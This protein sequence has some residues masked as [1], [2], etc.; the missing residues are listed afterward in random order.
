LFHRAEFNAWV[1]KDSEKPVLWLN[2]KHG[3]GK[4][5]L[6]AA[7]TRRLP[8]LGQG[9]WSP[10]GN[11]DT[12]QSSPNPLSPF[13]IRQFF[14]KDEYIP[15]RQLFGAIATQ[16]VDALI[17]MAYDAVPESIEPFLHVNNNSAE[18]LQRLIHAT[19]LELPL[20]YIFVD[21][22]DEAEYAENPK[23]EGANWTTRP[24][25]DVKDFVQFLIQEARKT[26]AKVRV[27]LSSQ[28]LPDIRTYVYDAKW[29]GAIGEIQV[30][31]D[32][33][34][35]DITNYFSHHMPSPARNKN[36]FAELFFRFALKT[37]VEGS[38]LWASTMVDGF[39]EEVENDDDLV[40]LAAKGLPTHM[41]GVY[42]LI[43][44]KITKKN[45]TAREPPLWK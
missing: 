21:G 34:Q 36:P 15:P 20:T 14:S 27:W 16:L 1:E 2:G 13:I 22:L 33:T 29:S 18:N 39:K 19:L 9:T 7:A 24:P 12:K 8:Q 44:D 38:F 37:E 26:P 43:I 28:P 4:T 23:R 35:E 30:T 41:S 6:C 32:D 45:R 11:S 31:K 5:V 42:E 10:A 17:K 25:D 40:T 3:A